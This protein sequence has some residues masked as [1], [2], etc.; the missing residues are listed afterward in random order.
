MTR[1]KSK[2]KLTP[3]QI[4]LTSLL[5]VKASSEL[6]K[7]FFMSYKE[8]SLW[9]SLA[10]TL[11]LIYFYYSNM[12]GLQESQTLNADSFTV[13]LITTVIWLTIISIVS[14]IVLAIINHKEANDPEDERDK[15]IDLK[16]CRV[17]YGLL[18]AGVVLSIVHVQLNNLIGEYFG[19]S[20]TVDLV[21]FMHIIIMSFLVADMA[22]Y[23]TQLYYYRRGC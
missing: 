5:T 3:S 19:I 6:T 21:N 1:D 20:Q 10:L 4:Y 14:H 9:V 22:K 17:G 13:L 18:S 15:L 23:A 8:K 7:R 11:Y 2:D 12:L 16:G